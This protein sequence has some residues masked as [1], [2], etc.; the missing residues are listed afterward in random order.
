MRI[1]V[2][3]SS[4]AKIGG[5]HHEDLVKKSSSIDWLSGPLNEAELLALNFN[6]T[7]IVCGDD[8][9]T[10]KVLVRAKAGGLKVLSKYGIGLDK[11][12][13]KAADRLG[14]NVL[15]TPG[16]NSRAVAEHAL[17]ILL[18]Y[19]K[20]LFT[21]YTQT[22]K[23]NWQRPIGT[24]ISGKTAAII[25]FGSI[26]KETAKLFKAFDMKLMVYDP[27]VE[28][29]VI[30]DFGYNSASFE[31]IAKQSDIVSLHLP[32]NSSTSSLIN[33]KFLS[34]CTR[35][36]I[37]INTSRGDIVNPSDLL[38]ALDKGIISA[39]LTDVLAI[40]PMSSEDPFS[41]HERIWISPHIGS[42]NKETILRQGMQAVT[43]LLSAI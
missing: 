2:T 30:E 10:E 22:R 39:Y 42:R 23:N 34:K 29:T 17:A 13:L 6:Y 38:H 3:S 24:E 1:L 21:A 14:I 16:V 25:G 27:F 36:P 4:F 37:L 8:E 18:C 33:K 5:C 40:E 41:A 26:G 19:T 11:I 32:L 20:N 12:D 35:K 15:N 43:N 28:K 7:G 9:W 31:A